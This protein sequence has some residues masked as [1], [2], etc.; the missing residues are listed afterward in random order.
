MDLRDPLYRVCKMH[1]PN[2]EVLAFDGAGDE[3]F[4]D[5]TLHQYE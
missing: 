2:V 1:H 4:G 3:T 5:L